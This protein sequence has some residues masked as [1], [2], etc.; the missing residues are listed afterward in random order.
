MKYDT[1]VQTLLTISI[2]VLSAGVLACLVRAMIGPTRADR[3]I[4]ANM[5]GTHVICLICIYAAKT[6]EHGF[7]DAALIYAMFSFLA[8]AVLRRR[9]PPQLCYHPQH[10]VLQ[11]LQTTIPAYSAHIAL[12]LRLSPPPEEAPRR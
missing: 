3:L 12:P 6:G 5:T 10:P 7:T 11:H 2:T 8:A 1:A 4:A 9:L